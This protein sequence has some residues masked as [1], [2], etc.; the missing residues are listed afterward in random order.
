MPSARP[1]QQ[2]GEPTSPADHANRNSAF[3]I[4]IY[5]KAVRESSPHE[6]WYGVVDDAVELG[7]SIYLPATLGIPVACCGCNH[8]Q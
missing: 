3:L 5:A 1:L 7:V 4:I 6:W 2:T 8:L